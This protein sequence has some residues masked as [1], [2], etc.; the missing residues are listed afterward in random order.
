[1]RNSILAIILISFALC[2]S[3]FAQTNEWGADYATFD[4][5][6]NGTGDQT[7]SVATVGPN[8][9]VAIVAQTP[10]EPVLDN[11]FNSPGNYL[12]GYWDADS[13]LGRVPS[14][15]NGQQT[16]PIYNQD[17]QFTEWTSG[18]DQ[19]ILNGAYQLASD[20]SGRV[21][22]ANN[23]DF[24]NILVF[25]LTENGVTST[26]FRMETGSNHIFAIEV[27]DNGFVYVCDYEGND[28]KTDEIKVYAGVDAPGTSWG[29]FGVNDDP[30]TTIDLPEGN[31]LGLTVS[32]D[33]TA[34]FV[35]AT[36]QRS[37]WKYTGDPASGYTADAGFQ[38]T[39]AEDDTIANG[40]SGTP[41]LLGL[42][43][44]NDPPTV[45]AAVDSFIHIG[46]EG[47]YPYGRIYSFDPDHGGVL[48]TID[49]AEWNFA[50]TGSYSTGSS[51][52]RAGGFTSVVDV[53]VEAT[54]Q[55][56]Y[57]QTYYGWAVEK[58]VFD[59]TLVGI[60]QVTNQIPQTFSLKQNYPN[61][62]NP[63][64]IIEFDIQN[65]EFVTLE[66]YNAIGQK[67]A[68]LLNGNLSTGSYQ[69]EFDAT[70]LTSGIYFYKLTAGSFQAVKKMLLTK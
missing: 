30:V 65:P 53:D 15:I 41:S 70:G 4:D 31:Y 19:V 32:G 52:G 6:V 50:V 56:V 47:G 54:E 8:R 13:G 25:E 67:V 60:E 23:D 29:V 48:D 5:A 18:L 3:G 64:T 21:Y 51:N 68:T 45:F 16:L 1:M 43:Y 38:Y 34:I 35:S 12:V 39:M 20:N 44:L 49:V 28:D 61:P 17:A 14:P 26:D 2:L 40:G 10:L 33:G 69:A 42:A 37:L 59:G 7:S 46:S 66:I 24:H 63:S 58:W 36:T 57:T 9:F 27:D 11:L 22:V 55:A 62:F